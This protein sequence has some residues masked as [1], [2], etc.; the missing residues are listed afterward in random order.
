VNHHYSR[1]MLTIRETFEPR[2]VEVFDRLLGGE[3]VE[4]VG[5]S[6]GLSVQAVHKIKQRIRDRLKQLIALQIREENDPDG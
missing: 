5:A 3:G 1:A 2:S 4:E 6:F